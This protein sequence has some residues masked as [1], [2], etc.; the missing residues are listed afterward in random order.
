MDTET[1]LE[2]IAALKAHSDEVSRGLELLEGQ[3]VRKAIRTKVQ[4]ACSFIFV[5]FVGEGPPFDK[6]HT[7]QVYPGVTLARNYSS[8]G[9]IISVHLDKTL[10]YIRSTEFAAP[11]YDSKTGFYTLYL[12]LSVNTPQTIPTSTPS[13]V[14][15]MNRDYLMGLQFTQARD[16]VYRH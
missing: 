9:R 2:K 12:A 10:L 1:L 8:T 11:C 14:L 5:D 15:L 13:L 6:V 16:S 4:W 7:E 3:I